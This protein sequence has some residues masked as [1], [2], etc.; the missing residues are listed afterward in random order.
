MQKM[1]KEH[2]KQCSDYKRKLQKASEIKK[3]HQEIASLQAV[4]VVR[5]LATCNT[6]LSKE[7]ERVSKLEKEI[8]ELHDTLTELTENGSKKEQ[9]K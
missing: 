7:M 3:I 8:Q 9:N 2:K 6:A 4:N 1:A 5:R